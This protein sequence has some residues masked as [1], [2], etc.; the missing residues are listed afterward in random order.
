MKVWMLRIWMA[1][2]TQDFEL[3]STKDKAEA[4]ASTFMSMLDGINIRH[5]GPEEMSMDGGDVQCWTFDDSSGKDNR[6]F[7]EGLEVK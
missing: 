6:V 4:H 1:D 5:Y 3:Y 7:V 2:G